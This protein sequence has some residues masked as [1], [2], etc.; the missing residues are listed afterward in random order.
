MTG[1][2]TRAPVVGDGED[3]E[4]VLL[5]VLR[6][7]VRDLVGRWRDEGRYT[8]RSDSWLRSFDPA[9]SRELAARRL[10][11]ITWPRRFGG[12]EGSN[13]MRLAVTEELLRAGAPV[14]A[15]WI[16]DRQIGPAILRHGSDR[17]Q[18]EILPGITAGRYLFCL[19]MSEP[20]AGSDLA[21]VRTFATP[22]DGG[23]RVS[24][25]K[26]WT[27]IAQHA[28]H[29]Y[30]LVR[31]ERRERKH[32][33][34]TEF[35][36]D[37]DS[38]GIAV[39]PIIDM[40]GEHHFNEVLLDDVFVPGHRVLGQPAAGWSQVVE[41][42]SFERGGP[43]RVLS[44][45]PLLVSLLAELP[46]TADPELTRK[47]GMLAARL[48]VMRRMCGDVARAMDRGEAPAEQA[49]TLK[50][51]GSQFE[52]DVIEVARPLLGTQ[53]AGPDTAFGHA[54]LASP[55]FSI[56]GGASDVLLSIIARQERT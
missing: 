48:A 44:T 16:A 6:T 29:I 28:T 35:I 25:R 38:P 5:R 36:V 26:V 47:I 46:G 17:L 54:L 42:L 13:V 50:Y 11:G 12:R 37:M 1:T 20:G 22:A 2:G 39:S 10:I 9:F 52:R 40:A 15:H 33:G 8:P 49:A 41:Q 32:E 7:E 23:W 18:E 51:L 27:S 55:G 31:T 30:L 3:G 43:E 34:L 53:Q 21:A 19:G 56:R 45:Y 4:D 24:G 14:A